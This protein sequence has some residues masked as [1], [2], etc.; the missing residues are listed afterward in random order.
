MAKFDASGL[1]DLMRD[2]DALTFDKLAPKMLEESAPIV[3]NEL[4]RRLNKH[5][6]TGALVRSL[7]T[8]KP[9]QTGDGYSVVVRPTGEDKRG[10]RNA[11][12]LA[13]LEYGTPVQTATPI[14]L[15]AVRATDNKVTEKMQEVFN[16][17]VDAW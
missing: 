8:T 7:K 9:A 12:K 6:D 17:E 13:Y 16:M 1:D 14:V 2:V 3:E 5:I 15:P 11:E 4:K 10:T